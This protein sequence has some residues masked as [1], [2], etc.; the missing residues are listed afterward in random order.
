MN[1][2]SDFESTTEVT[3][4]QSSMILEMHDRPPFAGTFMAR[5]FLPSPGLPKGGDIPQIAERWTALRIE[6]NHLAAFRVATGGR[7]DDGISVLYPHVLGFR[8]QMALLTHPAFPLPIWKALQIRNRLVLHREI[9]PGE[10]LDL[11]TRTGAHR[12]AG[13]GVEIDLHSCL[14]RGSD[15]VW[16]SVITYFYRG[17]FGEATAD[18]HALSSPEVAGESLV[19]RFRMPTGGGW[20]FGTLTG[21]YNGIHW[22]P[23][24]SRRF[25]FRAAF[26]HPQRVVGICMSRL[27]SNNAVPQ[28]LDV[29][30]K[31]PVFYGAQV[32]LSVDRRDDS[33][34]F[35]L[36]LDGDPRMAL[37]ASWRHEASNCGTS[38][39]SPS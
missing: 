14:S 22:W 10:T 37:V 11:E 17:R 27:C 4:V 34:R 18:A 3:T 8:L 12:T 5:A 15:C 21:D 20:R 39:T 2:R 16:E 6:P 24:Y 32:A 36:S 19:E 35:G 30:I 23:W 25:G 26:L 9:L 7:H 38:G 31:G 13:K 1:G 29:W 33:V 28:T